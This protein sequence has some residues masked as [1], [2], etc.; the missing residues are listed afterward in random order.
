M[1]HKNDTK[2]QPLGN[3]KSPA[4]QFYPGDYLKD[5]K[6]N[7]L[8]STQEAAYWRL[9]CFC[10]TEGN[11]PNNAP[12]LHML[13]KRDASLED[14]EHVIA[15]MFIKKGDRL[16]HK[17]LEIER[18]R[19]AENRVK[20]QKAAKKRWLDSQQVD[21]KCNANAMQMQCLSS[22]SST[23]VISRSKDLDKASLSFP[24]KLDHVIAK[25]ALDEWLEYKRQRGEK[26]KSIGSIQKLLNQYS[27]LSPPEFAEAVNHSMANNYKG[28]FPKP[29]E[30]SKNGNNQKSFEQRMEDLAKL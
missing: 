4:F 13:C 17:R 24:P 23:S 30:Y 16:Y 29:K 25:S 21:S 19:Q 8:T 18:L 10:W 22:S 6:V 26:Y 12:A 2:P 20:K 1:T 9:V 3:N 5:A 11:L 28:L 27:N 7:S 15:L 14:I